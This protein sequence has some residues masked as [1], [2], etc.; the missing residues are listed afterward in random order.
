MPLL[1]ILLML[2][3]ALMGSIYSD[4]A[5]EDGCNQLKVIKIKNVKY[6]CEILGDQKLNWTPS[7]AK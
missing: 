7:K 6:K 3:G 5:Y 2:F 4:N 1:I